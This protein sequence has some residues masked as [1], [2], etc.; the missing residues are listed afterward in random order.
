[1]VLGEQRSNHLTEQDY[2]AMGLVD[3]LKGLLQAGGSLETFKQNLA[4][5][6]QPQE[7]EKDQDL[8]INVL[9]LMV[10]NGMIEKQDILKAVGAATNLKPQELK[11]MIKEIQGEVTVNLSRQ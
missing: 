1:M 10:R 5:V 2:Q 11:L 3:E 4:E 9:G 6:Y 7:G 8:L